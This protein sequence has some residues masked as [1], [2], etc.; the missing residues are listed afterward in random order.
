MRGKAH[1]DDQRA[2][3]IQ[4]ARSRDLS[5]ASRDVQLDAIMS[6]NR[7]SIT[8]RLPDLR[9]DVG[10]SYCRGLY[11]AAA[12]LLLIQESSDDDADNDDGMKCSNSITQSRVVSSP[13]CTDSYYTVL[14]PC[15]DRAQYL[16]SQLGKMFPVYAFPFK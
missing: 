8:R 11:T 12:I 5:Y 2:K 13:K 4:T 15:N 10:P 14:N 3:L 6:A 9:G 1:E 7:V 16:M